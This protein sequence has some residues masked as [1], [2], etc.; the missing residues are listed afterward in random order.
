VSGLRPRA[1]GAASAGQ[2]GPV[3]GWYLRELGLQPRAGGAAARAEPA[4]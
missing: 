1:G 4:L 2:T 3:P